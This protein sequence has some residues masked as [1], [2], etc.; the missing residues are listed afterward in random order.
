MG[1]RLRKIKNTYYFVAYDAQRTPKEKSYPLHVKM[2]SAAQKKY[3][4]LLRQY[5]DDKWSPWDPKPPCKVMTVCSAVERF[6]ERR[7]L[8]STALRAYRSA[9]VTSLCGSLPLN[10]S[11]ICVRSIYGPSFR[12]TL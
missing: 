6:L 1:A 5:E 4:D 7:D 2:K 11:A 12:T 10:L 3:A 9:L 8:R